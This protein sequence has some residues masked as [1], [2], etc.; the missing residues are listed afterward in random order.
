[1]Q[2]KADEALASLLATGATL[3][4]SSSQ[5]ETAD[6]VHKL[7]VREGAGGY[8]IPAQAASLTDQHPVGHLP[9][10]QRALLCRVV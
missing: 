3:L 7:A 1:V 4:H 5:D 10:Q 6:L 2:Q 9:P 8:A